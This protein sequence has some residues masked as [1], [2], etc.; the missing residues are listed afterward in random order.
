[1]P[2]N[3]GFF[4]NRR[5]PEDRQNV[6]LA[7]ELHRKVETLMDGLKK[8]DKITNNPALR[9]AAGHLES[10]AGKINTIVEEFTHHSMQDI[11]KKDPS[12]SGFRI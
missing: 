12:N 6:T 7:K 4:G 1:M 11:D 10:V 9:T 8:I 5:N 3:N 2:T